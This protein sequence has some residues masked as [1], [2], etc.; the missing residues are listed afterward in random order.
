M[1][2]KLLES[3]VAQCRA[4]IEAGDCHGESPPVERLIEA[5]V[6]LAAALAPARLSEEQE[7]EEFMRWNL[8]G[9]EAALAFHDLNT[10]AQVR[11]AFIDGLR[12][13]IARGVTLS[14]SQANR[15]AGTGAIPLPDDSGGEQ[16]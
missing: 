13:G 9:T 12:R 16:P 5:V 7:G 2:P 15:S 3:T 14:A 4:Y 1:H 6:Q 10:H 11:Q 8:P